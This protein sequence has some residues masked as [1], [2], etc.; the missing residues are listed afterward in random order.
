VTSASSSSKAYL[1]LQTKGQKNSGSIEIR[2][3]RAYAVQQ[4]TL[5]FKKIP[6]STR[7]QSL[8]PSILFTKI[9]P[10]KYKVF[11]TKAKSPYLL[12]FS[13]AFSK[14]WKVYLNTDKPSKAMSIA[15]TASYFNGDVKEGNHG[16]VFFDSHTFETLGKTPLREE[17]HFTANGYANAWEIMPQDTGNKESYELIVELRSQQIFYM[18]L[19]FSLVSFAIC[20][21][22]L[23]KSLINLRK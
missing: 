12:V 19:A 13:E 9:N 20:I 4:P 6:S 2:N 5:F 18:S 15:T 7:G 17:K 11:V 1:Q 14:N 16:N 8:I 22:L 3:V 10:T 23:I 21:F